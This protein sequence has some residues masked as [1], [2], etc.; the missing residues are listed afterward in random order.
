MTKSRKKSGHE[1]SKGVDERQL[2]VLVADLP[3][4]ADDAM[5]DE[6]PDSAPEPVESF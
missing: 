5:P 2:S 6:I 3:P 1:G 4:L